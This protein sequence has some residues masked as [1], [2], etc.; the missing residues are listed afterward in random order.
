MGDQVLVSIAVVFVAI[1][2]AVVSAILLLGPLLLVKRLAVIALLKI[3]RR[4]R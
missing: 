2:L 1:V 4:K 3:V